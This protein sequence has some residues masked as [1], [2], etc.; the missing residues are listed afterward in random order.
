MLDHIRNAML[1]SAVFVS[2]A[3]MA[4]LVVFIGDLNQRRTNALLANIRL[5]DG[6]HEGLLIL[7][8]SSQNTMFINNAATK[9][10]KN[11]LVGKQDKNSLIANQIKNCHTKTVFLP[12][13]S[14]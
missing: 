2:Q 9:L 4:I 1:V 5:L 12:F 14:P 10:I 3:G 13:K 6:M 11:Y 8:K 7:S